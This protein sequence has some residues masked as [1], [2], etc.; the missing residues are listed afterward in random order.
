MNEI[1]NQLMGSLI[2]TIMTFSLIYFSILCKKKNKKTG[3]KNPSKEV[4][5]K[6]VAAFPIEF[7]Y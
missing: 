2:I 1:L 6:V 5:E 7:R 3:A 4:I